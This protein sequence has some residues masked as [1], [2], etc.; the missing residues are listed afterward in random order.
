TWQMTEQERRIAYLP[1]ARA[2]LLEALG[3]DPLDAYY[4]LWILE[5]TPRQ[6]DLRYILPLLSHE[7]DILRHAA[8]DPVDALN[9]TDQ[10]QWRDVWL[11]AAKNPNGEWWRNRILYGLDE[12][13]RSLS[14]P[15]LIS[16]MG[17]FPEEYSNEVREWLLDYNISDSRWS[18]AWRNAL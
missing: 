6:D 16:L 5:Q 4:A 12:L 2:R 1:E 13:D 3:K 9:L 8:L 18:D 15:A 17:H 14:I 11:A 10:K 7:D